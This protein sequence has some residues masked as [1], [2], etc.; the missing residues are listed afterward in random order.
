MGTLFAPALFPVYVR[1]AREY[2]LPFFMIRFPNAP[3][4]MLTQLRDGDILLDALA[5]ANE[6]VRPEQWRDYYAGVLR[7]LKPGLTQLIVHLGYDDAELQ[8]IAVDHPAFGSA[9][10]QRDF[11]VVTS[12]E[13]KKLLEENHIIVV[14]WRDLQK[15]LPSR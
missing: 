4:Q 10:R 7:S 12:P 8:A 13:F 9:W 2:G 11:E 3:P 6:R 14:G 1:V 15:L 5:M